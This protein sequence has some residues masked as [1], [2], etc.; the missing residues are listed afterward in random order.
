MVY[1]LEHLM[2]RRRGR[3]QWIWESNSK[4]LEMNTIHPMRYPSIQTC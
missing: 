1:P 3:E 2:A 4:T